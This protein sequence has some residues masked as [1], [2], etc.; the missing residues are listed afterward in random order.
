MKSK[1]L[2]VIVDRA[3]YGR[4]FPLI[5]SS[6]L[7]ERFHVSTCFLG[8]SVLDEFGNISSFCERDGIKVDYRLYIEFPGRSHI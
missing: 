6:Y 5:R 3:N 8:T 4:L 1:I 7:D 2:F